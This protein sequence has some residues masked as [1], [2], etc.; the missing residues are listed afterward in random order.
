MNED[1]IESLLEDM[2][3]GQKTVIGL[4]NM[5]K[6]NLCKIDTMMLKITNHIE[7]KNR[8][9]KNMADDVKIRNV[10]KT[11]MELEETIAELR[12]RMNVKPDEF[13]NVLVINP[14]NLKELGIEWIKEIKKK[15]NIE[16]ELM[17]DGSMKIDAIEDA[18]DK[19]AYGRAIGK[20]STIAHI[21]GVT[22]DDLK[23][24]QKP[25]T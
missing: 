2:V 20:I 12:K 1:R 23:D 24:E 3:S 21:F 4:L 25:T 13:E 5:I 8:G 22:E 7:S 14:V 6:N 17:K 15:D 11:A 19:Y 10:P 9:G 18:P 16:C